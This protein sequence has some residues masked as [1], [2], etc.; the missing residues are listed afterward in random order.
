MSRRSRVVGVS[1][2]E[3][4]CQVRK[5]VCRWSRERESI[6]VQDEVDLGQNVQQRVDIWRSS[7]ASFEDFE[8]DEW[9]ER[10][11]LET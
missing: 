9:K 7:D 5:K 3:D 4:R 8:V 6:L 11:M 10:N 2:G 1:E